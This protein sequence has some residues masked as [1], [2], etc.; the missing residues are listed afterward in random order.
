MKNKDIDDLLANSLKSLGEQ[1]VDGSITRQV[2]QRVALE[3][4]VAQRRSLPREVVLCFGLL[5]G[6]GSGLPA[7]I[8]LTAWLPQAS[9]GLP[10]FGAWR[11]E[12]VAW[13]S[14][15]TWDSSFVVAALAAAAMSLLVLFPALE[16]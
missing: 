5:L 4:P 10:E 16:D 8:D 3:E 6:L 14:A 7:F 9:A 2:M 12:M 1:P 13:T 15:Q 11:D